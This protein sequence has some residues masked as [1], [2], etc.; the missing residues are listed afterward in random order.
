MENDGIE[1]KL[2]IKLMKDDNPVKSVI[3]NSCADELISLALPT[4]ARPN[5]RKHIRF[6]I[7][8]L[9]LSELAS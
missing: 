5:K 3:K 2:E 4:Q 7:F 9:F 8:T 1:T 6:L